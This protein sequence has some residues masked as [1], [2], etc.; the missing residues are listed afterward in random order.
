MTV[1]C[2]RCINCRLNR[3]QQWAIRITHE[4]QLHDTNSFVTL[5]Y[6]DENLPLHNSLNPRHFTLFMKRLRKNL[7]T[8][9][10]KHEQNL[11]PITKKILNITVQPPA[12]V[13]VAAKSPGDRP[14][15]H[16]SPPLIE[17][18]SYTG[19]NLEELAGGASSNRAKRG[20]LR[21]YHCGEYGGQTR[22]PHYHAILF[23][24]RPDD[25][26]LWS[27]KGGNKL[28]L[29]P[30]LTEIW[31]LGNVWFGDVS[32]QSANYVSRYVVKK[33]S[34]PAAFEHYTSIDGITG[35]IVPIYPEYATMSRRPGIG[36]DWFEK[37]SDY[38]YAHDH[39]ILNGKAVKPPLFYDNRLKNSDPA[40][41]SK[42]RSARNSAEN[43]PEN[44]DPDRHY[45]Q[46][47]RAKDT[48]TKARLIERKGDYK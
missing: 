44:R 42:V 2:G 7:T 33:I 40:K 43:L 35:E 45:E 46:E 19:R 17:A 36:A 14:G 6:S 32:P 5:T 26:I 16:P 4:A 31:G 48:I 1:P 34:G 29:S 23:G 37:Y 47:M 3:A 10:Q 12:Y 39:V 11:T 18:G 15:V 8:Q 21:Y 41:W 30:Y 24:F 13:D 27:E 25:G 20:P 22:R 28:W 9:K 38:T